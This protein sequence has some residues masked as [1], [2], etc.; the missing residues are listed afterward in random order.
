MKLIKSAIHYPAILLLF[1]LMYSCDDKCETTYTYKYYE[2]V[3]LTVAEIRNSV[4][5]RSSEDISYPGKIYRFDHYLFINEVGKGI[6][7]IDNYDPSSPVNLAFLNIPGN[8]DMAIKD[9]ILYADSYV[10][11]LVFDMN[12]VNNITLLKRLASVFQDIYPLT[13][14]PDGESAITTEWKETES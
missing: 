9:K 10:D 14:T 7:I 8:F 13:T 1:F 2:P 12:D 5:L 4:S 11:L 3:Y 6:H